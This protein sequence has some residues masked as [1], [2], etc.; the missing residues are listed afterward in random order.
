M[1]SRRRGRPAVDGLMCGLLRL[2][3]VVVLTTAV[4]A[5]SSGR[6]PSPELPGKRQAVPVMSDAEAPVPNVG[7]APFRMVRLGAYR[8]SP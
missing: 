4:S 3:W 6:H 1:I 8:L 7:S 2:R 5:R